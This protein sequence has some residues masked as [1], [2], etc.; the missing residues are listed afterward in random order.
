MS[1][2][3]G[4]LRYLSLVVPLIKVGDEVVHKELGDRMERAA[5]TVSSLEVEQDS[6]NAVK[7]MLMLPVQVP[8]I[9]GDFI[10]TSINAA[11]PNVNTGSSKLKR[12]DTI[13]I[14]SS[15]DQ[16]SPKDMFTIGASHTL[17]ATHVEFF[18]DEDEP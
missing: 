16:D 4:T 13:L 15:Y 5:T 17:E 14:C 2:E 18:S 9:E 1:K 11:S 7:H 8:A 12:V 6:V 3:V 10:N